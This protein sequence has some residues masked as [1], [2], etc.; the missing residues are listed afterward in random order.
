MLMIGE[1][2]IADICII[3][4]F[5]TSSS[6]NYVASMRYLKGSVDIVRCHVSAD[7]WRSYRFIY[8]YILII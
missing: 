6:A 5:V 7:E 2:E 8:R 3:S 1:N 4:S